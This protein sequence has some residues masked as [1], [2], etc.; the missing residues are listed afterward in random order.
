[1][2]LDSCVACGG[3]RL[4]RVADLG[5]SPV[6]TGALFDDRATARRAVCGPLDLGICVDCGHV[7]NV[8]FDPTLVQYDVSYDNS[9]H[10]SATFQQYA[11]ELV[12]HLVEKYDI[13][14]KRI[15]E[16]GSGKGDFLRS[17]CAVGDNTGTGYDPTVEQDTE[18][19]GVRLVKDYFRPG[20][21]VEAYDLLV[22]RHVLEHLNDPA[23]LLR[24]LAEAAPRGA[25]FYFEVPAAE[26][27]FGPD[28][29]WDCIYPH[30]S[31]FSQN[32]LALLL[33][34]CGF[35]VLNLRRSFHGQFLSVE[36]LPSVGAGADWRSADIGPHLAL[37]EQFT[38]CYHQAVATWRTAVSSARDRG[39][40]VVVWGVG[41]KGV[42]FLRAAD[43]A[44]ELLAV[45]INPRKWG[46]YL[47]GTG[48]EVVAPSELP[49]R[50]VSTVAVT[51]PVYVDE[52]SQIL[53]ELGVDA[54]VM[55]V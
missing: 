29:L 9:L 41:S 34:R 23:T 25:L 52:I 16:I 33:Q 15:V 54:A 4:K 20:D 14:G 47:P 51:N 22:C 10:F 17:I 27:N 43:P 21:H 38:E 12:A 31:Y 7:Q 39:E 24:S 11:D 55:T 3:Q 36:A 19:P 46:K 2:P 26:F 49:D 40:L 37:V 50:P 5:A 35:D 42:N 32:S 18:I 45:D 30:V 48:H 8:A 1:M 53:T 44:G 13:R 28:G 6:L